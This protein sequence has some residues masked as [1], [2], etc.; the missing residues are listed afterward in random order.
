MGAWV[1]IKREKNLSAVAIADNLHKS[2]QVNLRVALNRL[3]KFID[4]PML[5]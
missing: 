1:R 4:D 2:E 5:V 3:Q